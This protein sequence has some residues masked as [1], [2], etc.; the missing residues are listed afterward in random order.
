VVVEGLPP[1]SV[2]PYEVFF[3]GEKAWPP[4]EYTYPQPA[5]R[6]RPADAP[7]RILFGS[8]RE[9]SP[10]HTDRFPPDALDAYAV[11]LSGRVQSPEP[12]EWPDLLL[13][14]GD[15]VYADETSTTMRRVL[16]ERKAQR[17]PDAP[18]EQVVDFHEYTQLYVDSWTDPDIRWLL[19]TVPSAMIFDDHEIIDDWNISDTWRTDI[20]R[21]SWWATRIKAGL[22][23]YWVYQHLGNIPPSEVEKDPVYAAVRASAADATAVLDEFGTRADDD[24]ASYRWSYSL[25][26]G[27]T[28]VVVLDNRAGRQLVP[29]RRAMASE[30]EWA[31]LRD[32]VSGDHDHV[33]LGS[34]LPWLMPPAIHHLEAASERLT[35][36]RRPWVAR[37]AEKLRRRVDLE[38]WAAF[39]T[40]FDALADL[41]TEVADAEGG[42]AT[43]CVLSGDVHH[44]YV[45]RA[46]LPT[47][48]PVY[49]LTC[50]PVHNALPGFMKPAMRFSWSRAA[51]AIGRG[52]AKAAGLPPPVLSWRRVA[53]PVYQNAV[54][55]LTHDGR[56]ATVTIEGTEPDKQLHRVV[57]VP[58]S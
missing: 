11:R 1:D 52:I 58:L 3:D 5:I 36:S 38:H 12:T 29:G 37:R 20:A 13:L 14:L 21:E 49:Q 39:G 31:W 56:H 41:L 28:R 16:A 48:S 4:P 57:Q 44:S 55:E 25:D 15:Q 35:E 9:S 23:T 53:G 26:L 45:A 47:R 24:A 6:T 19:S 43:V 18:D 2:V 22:A 17:R 50:S 46:D 32:A 8:C 34:S 51:A 30:T 40:S 33:V 27:R 10:L 42:P 54:S 7:V